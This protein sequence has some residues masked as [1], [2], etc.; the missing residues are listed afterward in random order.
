[1]RSGCGGSARPSPRDIK[2]G[3]A[4]TVVLGE[5]YTQVVQQRR[6]V[7]LAQLG[8]VSDAVLAVGIGRWGLSGQ[9]AGWVGVSCG[10]VDGRKGMD[11]LLGGCGWWNEES[12]Y[13][14]SGSG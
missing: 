10:W 7:E 4:R 2:Q 8:V 1:M 3:R 5:A 11:G 13:S 14:W 6:L 12:S 9:V